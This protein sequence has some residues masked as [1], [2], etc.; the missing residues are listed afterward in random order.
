MPQ[1]SLSDADAK[2]ILKEVWADRPQK[3]WKHKSK[4]VRWIRAQPKKGDAPCPVLMRP[5][6][7]K[8]Q[9]TI[10]DGLYIHLDLGCEN[11]AAGIRFGVE[12][13]SNDD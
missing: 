1:E 6:S 13:R 5:G 3:L 8:L 2:G 11:Y 7:R 12:V 10:P 9:R 4:D